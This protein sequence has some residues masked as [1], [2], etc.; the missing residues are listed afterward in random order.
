MSLIKRMFRVFLKRGP[1]NNRVDKLKWKM[2]FW[3][4]NLIYIRLILVWIEILC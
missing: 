4:I 2:E 1:L 3:Y